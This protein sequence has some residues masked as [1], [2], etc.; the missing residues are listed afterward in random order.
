[1]LRYRLGDDGTARLKT[2]QRCG[3]ATKKD[4]VSASLEGR[5]NPVLNLLF[6]PSKHGR[7]FQEIGRRLASGESVRPPA[8]DEIRHLLKTAQHGYWVA[9][10]RSSRHSPRC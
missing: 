6:T 2:K 4:A 9:T 3:A 5:Q 7:Y 10:P 8:P 1:M